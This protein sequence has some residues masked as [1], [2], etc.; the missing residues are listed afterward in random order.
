MYTIKQIPE[1]FHV[2]ERMRLQLQP[3]GLYAFAVLTKKRWST[4]DALTAL[5]KACDLPRERFKAAGM[6]DRDGISEQ[7]ISCEGLT[8]E[9]VEGIQIRDLSLKFVGY[10]N[11]H[12]GLAQH[13]ANEFRI[14]VRNLTVPLH[15]LT[16]LCNYYDDQRFGGV[17]PNTHLIG[18]ALLRREFEKAVYI[19]LAEQYPSEPK[20]YAP[21]RKQL[22]RKWG[23]WFLSDIPNVLRTERVVVKHLLD[24][25]GDFQGAFWEIQRQISTL[26]IHAFQSYLFNEILA[27]YIEKAGKEAWSEGITGKLPL[28]DKELPV[29]IP[30]VGYDYDP[31]KDPV[32]DITQEV[33][34]RHGIAPGAFDFQEL[35]FLSSRTI[36][37]PA[38]IPIKAKVSEP[39]KDTLNPEKLTQ[40]VSFDLPKGSY[41]TFV[42]DSMFWLSQKKKPKKGEKMEDKS[43]L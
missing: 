19:L 40:S 29:K 30:L 8:K 3:D 11:H 28:V 10:G 33:L 38:T 36:Y 27:E 9:Q 25:P 6:K 5:A 14:V 23:K 20:G 22:A 16:W 31:Q 7:Y 1:D 37:R 18:E 42:I 26:Y 17:R 35:P 39:K 24:N 41:A 34:V 21:V 4:P 43:P 12:I 2:K 32:A 15:P 13:E